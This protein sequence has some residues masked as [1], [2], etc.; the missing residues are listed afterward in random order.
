MKIHNVVNIKKKKIILKDL[1]MSSHAEQNACFPTYS[2]FSLFQLF[3][4]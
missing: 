2:K 4:C 3:L 1:W